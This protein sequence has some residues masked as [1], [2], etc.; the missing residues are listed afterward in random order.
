VAITIKT[1][2]AEI[3]AELNSSSV[4]LFATWMG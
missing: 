2:M 4:T 3:Y 1:W